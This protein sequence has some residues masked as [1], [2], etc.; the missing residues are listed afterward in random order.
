MFHATSAPGRGVVPGLARI[1]RDYSP[2]RGR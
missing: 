1:I 2:V